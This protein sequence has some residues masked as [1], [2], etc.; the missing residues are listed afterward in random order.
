MIT[1]TEVIFKG[2]FIKVNLSFLKT[3]IK[4]S[5]ETRFN[6]PETRVLLAYDDIVRAFS[7][8]DYVDFVLSA[9][10]VEIG[11][12]FIPNVFVN[13]GLNE[14]IYE[15]LLFFD[16]ADINSKSHMESIN[17][18][19]EWTNK[20]QKQY[21]FEYLICQLDNGNQNEYYF[22]SNGIG[23]LYRYVKNNIL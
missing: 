17:L 16:L 21:G 9:N 18:L 11:D 8:S 7:S 13:L 12:K 4:D 6:F 3:F 15:L 1:L 5:K 19:K 23:P 22:D 10:K 20:F 14:G 2:S